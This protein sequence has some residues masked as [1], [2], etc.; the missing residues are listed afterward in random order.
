MGLLDKLTKEGLISLKDKL[1]QATGVDLDAAVEK[2]V[3]T[4]KQETP[5]SAAETETPTAAAE[6][7]AALKARF[8]SILSEEFSAYEVKTD[9]APAQLGAAAAPARA[10]DFALYKGGRAAGVIL[11]TPHNRDRNAAFKNARAAAQKA[12]V[13]FINFYEHYPNERSYIVTRIKSFL[14]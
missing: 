14:K 8:A 6:T 5:Q 10:Y 4:A 11:L 12:G 13:P 2:L 3:E 9:V 7:P 1:E